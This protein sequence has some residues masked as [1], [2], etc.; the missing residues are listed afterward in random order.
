NCESLGEVAIKEVDA[1]M[2]IFLNEH[3]ANILIYK[4]DIKISDFGFSRKL[5]SMIKTKSENFYGVVPFVDPKKLDNFKHKCDK[6]SDVYSFGVLMWEIS[7]DGC[8]PFAL[9]TSSTLAANIIGGLRETP[10]SGT[11]MYYVNLYVDCWNKEP[12]KRPSM[13]EVFR[14]L[15]S[16]S[17]ELD[18]KYNSS[19]QDFKE[20]IN[21]SDSKSDDL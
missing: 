10:V 21:N 3:T 8:I 11:P 12:D 4:G 9:E 7:N 13:E 5:D 16:K 17:L 19:D 2:E 6:K 1:D 15:K 18:P 14:K 20:D